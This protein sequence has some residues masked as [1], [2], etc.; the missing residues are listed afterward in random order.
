MALAALQTGAAAKHGEVEVAKQ[1]VVFQRYCHVYAAGE[2]SELF[3]DARLTG[4]V[5]VEEEYYDAGN[6]CVVARRVR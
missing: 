5:E 2:L 4:W 3:G 6:W 1:S